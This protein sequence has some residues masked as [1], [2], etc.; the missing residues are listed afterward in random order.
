[1]RSV[2]GLTRGLLA[3]DSAFVE[4]DPVAPPGNPSLK[5]IK[6]I[7]RQ[8]G[9]DPLLL[10]GMLAAAGI[11]LVGW[12]LFRRRRRPVASPIIPQSLVT[13]VADLGPYEAAV[14]RL[15]QIQNGPWAA[16]GEVDR[17]YE[18]VADAL[19][20]YLEDAHG[21][22]ALTHTTSGLIRALPPALRDGGLL[23]RCAAVLGE[24]DL[25]KFA[26][27]ERDAQAGRAFAADARALLDA[28]HAVSHAAAVPEEAAVALR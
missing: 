24:A 13:P 12:L 18:A 1:M 14:A 27:E 19:R 20:H 16:P 26:R 3:S 11:A 10:S 22:P 15:E 7:V 9:P 17:Y 2:K 8:R 25:V 4:I 6:P 5:D 23:E 28:W 21:V